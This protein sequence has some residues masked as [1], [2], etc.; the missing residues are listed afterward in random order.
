MPRNLRDAKHEN[1]CGIIEYSRWRRRY[2]KSGRRGELA[3]LF[4]LAFGVS[5]KRVQPPNPHPDPR[6]R[7]L[8][9]DGIIR[10]NLCYDDLVSNP[11]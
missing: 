1:V 9:A 7:D 4:S 3:R 5:L 10:G 8:Q 6:E 2:S 11:K